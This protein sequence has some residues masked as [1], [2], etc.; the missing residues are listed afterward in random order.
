MEFDRKYLLNL[1]HSNI[2]FDI[3][4]SAVG[5][6]YKIPHMHLSQF[7]APGYTFELNIKGDITLLFG[8][9]CR[10]NHRTFLIQYRSR[11]LTPFCG[12][13]VQNSILA[14][15]SFK[16]PVS[17]FDLNKC[18][19]TFPF[20]ILHMIF[21]EP[22]TQHRNWNLTL[23]C[24]LAVQNHI[25]TLK[26]VKGPDNNFDLNLKWGGQELCRWEFYSK[27]VY[28]NPQISKLTFD[29][30]LLFQGAESHPGISAS[31]KPIH[32][33]W[34]KPQLCK[35][36][37]VGIL[38]DILIEPTPISNVKWEALQWT[39]SAESHTGKWASDVTVENYTGHIYEAHQ[40]TKQQSLKF[41][42]PM[43]TW[44]GHLKQ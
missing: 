9:F 34:S 39:W 27:Y 18:A 6:R 43:F 30:L 2:E 17:T 24:V 13:E 22:N 42:T 14:L 40:L 11:H 25:Q 41:D 29:T 21:I 28:P 12:I 8:N 23:C 10:D 3:W 26:S 31:C 1:S 19:R 32:F 35:N 38:Q 16:G 20:G 37:A 4:H 7:T 36:L 15:K 33:C 5:L 44:A